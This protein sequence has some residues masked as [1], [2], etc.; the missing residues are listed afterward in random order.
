MIDSLYVYV[1]LSTE[2][3]WGKKG[4]QSLCEG[5]DVTLFQYASVKIGVLCRPDIC[6]S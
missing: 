1:V 4:R 3:A 6:V 2:F 5:L